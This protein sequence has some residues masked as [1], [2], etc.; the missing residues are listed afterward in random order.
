MFHPY[1]DTRWSQALSGLVDK[2]QRR[3]PRPAGKSMQ[4][5]LGQPAASAGQVGHDRRYGRIGV[6]LLG[7][8]VSACVNTGQIENLT[9]TRRVTVAFESVDGP[10]PAVLHKFAS[11]L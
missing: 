11:G 1:G 5:G 8:A 6:L 4:G 2:A 10:P 7:L 9:E 3:L